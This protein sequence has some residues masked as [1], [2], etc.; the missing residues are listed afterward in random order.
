RGADLYSTNPRLRRPTFHQCPTQ[1]HYHHPLVAFRPD[2]VEIP[3]GTFVIGGTPDF[4]FVFDNEKWAHPLELKS[5]RIA[6]APVTNGEFLAFVEDGGYRKPQFWS[7]DGWRWLE[8]GGTPRL[9]SS[10][11][12]FFNQDVKQSPQPSGSKDKLD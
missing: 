7:A 11:A 6:R 12:K 2:D 9:E 8:L 3:G 10:F 1:N 4:P 5:F